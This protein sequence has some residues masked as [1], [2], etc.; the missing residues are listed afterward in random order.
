VIDEDSP[1]ALDD[2]PHSAGDRG[3]LDRALDDLDRAALLIDDDGKGR[4]FDDGRQHRRI[5]REV[6]NA[7]VL[8]PE[9]QGAEILDHAREAG[10]LRRSGET[11]LAARRNDDII[12]AAHQ[13]RP[14]GR[15]G[16]QRIAGGELIIH[17]QRGWPSAGMNH[18]GVAAELGDDPLVRGFVRCGRGRREQEGQCCERQ[19]QLEHGRL[20]DLSRV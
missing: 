8:D 15:P 19:S 3:D 20:H 6:R 9:Q 16:Q 13:S 4:S 14:A 1:A 17:G 7:G 5:D 2:L 12:A 11:E 10:G 18:A